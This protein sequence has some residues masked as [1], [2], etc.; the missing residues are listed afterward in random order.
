MK[1]KARRHL[2]KVYRKASKVQHA[3]AVKYVEAFKDY[4]KGTI[5]YAENMEIY[6]SLCEQTAK[7]NEAYNAYYLGFKRKRK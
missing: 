7:C 3:A 1:A 6:A 2:W 4:N 5:T